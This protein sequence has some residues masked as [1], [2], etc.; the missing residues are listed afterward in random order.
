MIHDEEIKALTELN[1]GLFE[2]LEVLTDARKHAQDKIDQLRQKL[3][4][5]LAER[6]GL[7]QEIDNTTRSLVSSNRVLINLLESDERFSSV[8]Q[9][10]NQYRSVSKA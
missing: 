4:R 8:R 9:K 1:R 3:E 2:H 6:D 5:A 7:D 10:L